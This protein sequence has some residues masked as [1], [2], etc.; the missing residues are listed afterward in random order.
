MFHQEA[1]VETIKLIQRILQYTPLFKIQQTT[2][3]SEVGRAIKCIFCL[4]GYRRCKCQRFYYNGQ[5]TRCQVTVNSYTRGGNTCAIK[6]RILQ[7][8]ISWRNHRPMVIYSDKQP[9]KRQ[10]RTTGVTSL[11]ATALRTPQRQQLILHFLFTVFHCNLVRQQGEENTEEEDCR[12]CKLTRIGVECS[13]VT[14]VKL[15]VFTLVNRHR[16]SSYF[17]HNIVVVF[18]FYLF[19]VVSFTTS[20]IDPTLL[21]LI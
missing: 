1:S 20:S 7:L 15:N 4:R 14:Y 17:V 9:P 13:H 10:T 19:P 21:L 6:S 11:S 5:G 12:L 16:T 8:K 2:F 3:V 18:I